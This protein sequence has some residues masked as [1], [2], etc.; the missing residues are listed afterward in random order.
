MITEKQIEAAARRYE[1]DCMRQDLSYADVD[2]IAGARWAAEQIQAENAELRAA[3]RAIFNAADA[4]HSRVY[5]ETL[6]AEISK[7]KTV[8]YK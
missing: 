1:S 6:F 7:A 5:A 3:L 4:D 2:F 8:L